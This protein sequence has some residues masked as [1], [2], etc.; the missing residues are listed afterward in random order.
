M[1]RGGRK[2]VR[3]L[4]LHLN[5]HCDAFRP[6]QRDAMPA[7]ACEPG[8]SLVASSESGFAFRTLR[9]K[10][11]GVELSCSERSMPRCSCQVVS[12]YFP[13]QKRIIVFCAVAFMI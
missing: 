1:L 2:L 8:R 12:F 4:H 7:F 6:V 5:Q 13:Q 11:A 10:G 3:E 9:Q